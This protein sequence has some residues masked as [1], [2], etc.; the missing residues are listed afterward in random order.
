VERGDVI[1]DR[2]EIERL[3]ASGGTAEIYKA[4][5]RVTG[6]RVAVKCLVGP[7]RARFER[8]ARVL[9]QLDHPAV[10]RY[11]GRGETPDGEAWLA[12]EWLEGES[13]A[14]R[15]AR[16]PLSIADTIELGIS[17]ADALGAAHARGMVHRDIKPENLFLVG[18]D[19]RAVKLLDFGIVR[20]G[21]LPRDTRAGMVLGTLGY[22]APEQAQSAATIDAR[23]DVF[24][25][26]CVLL[27]CLGGAPV[28]AADDLLGLLAKIVLDEVPR[29]AT[30]REGVPDALDDLLARMVQKD[31]AL[32]PRDGAVVAAELAA[33]LAEDGDARPRPSAPRPE[34]TQGERRIALVVLVGPGEASAPMDVLAAAV[35]AR[36]G[37]LTS[38]GDGSLAAALAGAGLAEDRAAQAAEC[39]VALRTLLPGRAVALAAGRSEAASGRPAGE[40][41]D[42]AARL[43][44]A[45]SKLPPAQRAAAVAVDEVAAALLERRFELNEGPAGIELTGERTTIAAARTLLGRATPC[46]GREREIGALVDV[47][48]RAVAEP[49]ARAALLTAPA[50]FGKSRLAEELCARLEGRAEIW[51]GRGD[52]SSA[53]S[54]YS[55][56]ASVLR[57][58]AGLSA[59]DPLP[60]C[61]EK[62]RARVARAVPAGDRARVAAFLGEIVGAPF[63]D[64][65]TPDLAAARRDAILMGAEVRRAFVD[66]VRAA[67]AWQ[68]LLIV[69][70]DLHWGDLPSL[71]LVG[72]ALDDLARR[73]LVVVGLGR[74]ELYDLCPR[75]WADHAAVEL[76]LGGLA[77]D[78]AAALVRAALGDDVAAD[79]VAR[80]VDQ[81]DGHPLYL[82][83]LIRAAA[84]GGGEALPETVLAMVET[85]LDRLPPEARRALR[86]ASVLGEIFWTGAVA[87]LLGDAAEADRRLAE[88]AAE[89]LVVR[90]PG[91]RFAGEDEWALC[92]ALV[93]E[94]AYATLTDEDRRLGHQLAGE[95][96]ERAGETDAMVLAAHFEAGEDPGR[97]VGWYVRAAQQAFEGDDLDAVLARAAR[98]EAS[99]AEGE[100]RGALDL[101]RAAAL[102]WRGDPE[103]AVRHGLAALARL[104]EGGP[105]WFAAARE[106]ILTANGAVLDEA[107]QR[108][109]AR[110]RDESV[111]AAQ[112]AALAAAHGRMLAEGRGAA[113]GEILQAIEAF[114]QL[115]AAR[116]AAA[117]AA[118]HDARAQ[119]AFFAGDASAFL[120]AAEAARASLGRAGDR[121]GAAAMR[122]A[123]GRARA[124]SGAPEDAEEV[125][126]AALAEATGLGLAPLA[127]RARIELAMVL[128]RLGRLEEA[129]ALVDL[130]VEASARADTASARRD[131]SAA[132][133][134]R[135]TILLLL[136]EEHG[137]EREAR[138]AVDLAGD[139]AAARATAL[140]ALAEVQLSERHAA[141]AL[142]TA[143]AARAV[144]RPDAL[145]SAESRARL[146]EIEALSA[147]GDT[148]AAYAALDAARAR[149]AVRAAVIGDPSLRASFLERVPEHARTL[150]LARLA[151]LP[152]RAEPSPSSLLRRVLPRGGV[153]SEAEICLREAE[154]ALARGNLDAAVARVERGMSHV[155]TSDVRAELRAV[156]ARAHGLRNAWAPAR[157]WAEQGMREA[158][159]GSRGWYAALAVRL[160]AAAELGEHAAIVGAADALPRLTIPTGAAR[161]AVIALSALSIGLAPLGE[162]ERAD[163]CH[164]R[165][166]RAGADLA[167]RD[168]VVRGHMARARAARARAL[169]QDPW[170]ALRFDEAAREAFAEAGDGGEVAISQALAGIDRWQLGAFER[171]AEALAA[172]RDG[173]GQRGYLTALASVHLAWT[174]ADAGKLDEAGAELLA[175]IKAE[176][177]RQSPALRAVESAV[178]AEVLRRRGDLLGAERAAEAAL[179]AEGIGP[180]YRTAVLATVAAVRLAQKRGAEA[181]ELARRARAEREARRLFGFRDAF[182]RL[183]HVE[184]L[185]AGGDMAG[186]RAPLSRACSRLLV[187]ASKIGDPALRA[188][189][190]ERIPEH[191]ETLALGRRWLG[192][193]GDHAFR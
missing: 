14:E 31:P 12:M 124:L 123:I 38:L 44:R 22:M 163:D 33:I 159:P 92:H 173:G 180:L 115:G 77:P 80:L 19:A 48:E 3:V 67:C 131:E 127:T 142:V 74:P 69:L 154:H 60:L 172:A 179:A 93:R 110:P 169:E 121:R 122:L 41:I 184:A 56:L 2:F 78:A 86:A 63:P 133:A 30:R 146:V 25:L 160:L 91:S 100:A 68:N 99:G 82:E 129:R 73:P 168:P 23:A 171:A 26:G 183:V 134:A 57:H 175:G 145:D 58:A 36:R 46:V 188:S 50:G 106:V 45:R 125:L 164:D 150:E 17:V 11:V 65:A 42:R 114:A 103:G 28:F 59:G 88:L 98:G 156:M 5:D 101:Y 191:R 177:A 20:I 66:L 147:I 96:L 190:L 153:A 8:E 138:L 76:R 135:A 70:D 120:R 112:L 13:L 162:N 71:G 116:D 119:R 37:Q 155:A 186:A 189:Y 158:S 52:R 40:A 94:A 83:E 104:V 151:G 10:V 167:G 102:R 87:A 54:T 139:D 126:M 137:P 7:Q 34:L 43:L 161:A 128:A 53:G 49:A 108:V 21:R 185:L 187:H 62:L 148:T 107:V 35:E 1:G 182:V 130:A 72:A 39:A 105:L 75:L 111:A 165:M 118:I 15:L 47:F 176:R 18:G 192:E 166:E 97:A 55:V 90:R 27:E 113:A 144:A 64:D 9:A 181:I 32:R 109:R 89:E 6:E 157:R 29:A 51:V 152:A 4:R 79:T 149:L 95:W 132:R 16:G 170:T 85:R 136:G 81:A 140:A 141:E 178:L 24:A 143:R 61:R 117:A 174:L 193:P 84:R